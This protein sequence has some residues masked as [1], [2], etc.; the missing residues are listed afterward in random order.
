MLIYDDDEDFETCFQ[1]R[2]LVEWEVQ[3]TTVHGARAKSI[4]EEGDVVLTELTTV[5]CAQ[6]TEPL[7]MPR[8]TRSES[9]LTAIEVA[10]DQEGVGVK[11]LA[12]CDSNEKLNLPPAVPGLDV[13][14][15]AAVA[16]N[17]DVLDHRAAE[18]SQDAKAHSREH[19]SRGSLN[20]PEMPNLDYTQTDSEEGVE[21][22]VEA[23]HEPQSSQE[24]T[25]M[26]VQATVKPVTAALDVEEGQ[27]E[28]SLPDYAV[29]PSGVESSSPKPEDHLQAPGHT[30][31]SG[32]SGKRGTRAILRRRSYRRPPTCGRYRTRRQS[33][34]AGGRRHRHPGKRSPFSSLSPPLKQPPS[35]ASICL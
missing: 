15:A 31:N 33:C 7:E 17:M 13:E 9:L 16:T 22:N 24:G 34:I 12:G 23:G 11:A 32:D 1:K 2:F 4:L 30:R 14:A 26:V 5:P 27:V 8:D 10:L 25:G 6:F 18:K 20:L 21:P 3:R 35:Q 28:Q 19:Q 29:C